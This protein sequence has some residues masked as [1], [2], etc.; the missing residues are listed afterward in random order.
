MKKEG[1][2]RARICLSCHRCR[3]CGRQ[4]P[5]AH[6]TAEQGGEWRNRRGDAGRI[7]RAGNVAHPRRPRR[8]HYRV[9]PSRRADQRDRSATLTTS[10]GL[11][12]YDFLLR[13]Q[14]RQ[15]NALLK[16]ATKLRLTPQSR[17]TPK[18]AGTAHRNSPKG[19]RPWE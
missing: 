8:E 4:P 16:T 17:Y 11:E 2:Y 6:L 3:S 13:A 18:A 10:P 12:R 9:S 15:T 7:F 5:P 19:R 1:L 14:A